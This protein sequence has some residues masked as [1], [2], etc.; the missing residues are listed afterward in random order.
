[1]GLISDHLFH[2]QG[3]SR[4]MV[5]TGTPA[6]VIVIMLYLCSRNGYEE[7]RRRLLLGARLPAFDGSPIPESR[8][9]R[10]PSAPPARV[11]TGS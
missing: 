2:G 9:A 8:A 7:L 5:W 4:A 10:A 3:L 6:A 11:G 1:V